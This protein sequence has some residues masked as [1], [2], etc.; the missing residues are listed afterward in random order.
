[1]GRG[2]SKDVAFSVVW[3]ALCAWFILIHYY[4]E[5]KGK[6]WYKEETDA[7]CYL[8]MSSFH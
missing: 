3:M 1:M 6:E 5:V 4:G 2:I 8:T 7:Q